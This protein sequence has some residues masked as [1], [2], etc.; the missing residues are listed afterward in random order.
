MSKSGSRY[1]RRSNW[2]KIHCLLQEQ[3]QAAQQ[4]QQQHQ[5]QQQQGNQKQSP[6][7]VL[8]MLGH[9]GPYPPGLYARPPCTK[10]EL[11]LLG[12]E[13]YHHHNKHPSASPSVSSPDSHNSDSSVDVG[14]RR[15][16]LLRH[17]SKL[18]EQSQALNKE[19]FLPLPFAGLPL[20]PPPGFLPPSHLLFSGYHPA[21]YPHHQGLLK[22]A[23][24]SQMLSTPLSL[25]SSNNNN[26]RYTPN[27]NNNNNNN[28]NL[29]NNNNSSNINKNNPNKSNKTAEV[30]SKRFFLDAVLESQR[31]P[32]NGTITEGENDEE[33]ENVAMTPPRSPCQN[34]SRKTPISPIIPTTTINNTTTTTTTNVTKVKSA[35][36]QDN[37]IDLSMKTGSSCTSDDNRP[38]S[39]ADS[40][41]NS[42]ASEDED[43]SS[44]GNTNNFRK[45][46]GGE[47]GGSRRNNHSIMSG[48]GEDD[49][50]DD[51]IYNREV[52]RMKFQGTT[53]LDLTTK[54]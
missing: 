11:M 17:N 9:P 39:G 3:Q 26:S 13:E 34:V 22:P 49:S 28:N 54:V 14:D 6:P 41:C 50:D 4:Q 31:S 8:N 36:A 32:S 23:I 24:E 44:P 42:I 2:F 46:G 29:N 52:K 53:P 1:G 33:N 10:E 38:S 51:T 45:N 25:S 5:Q 48:S 21:L 43:Q 37:P 19:L 30:F 18:Q 20:M 12:L 7:P 16:S 15:N 35:I 27:H 47:G 40:N